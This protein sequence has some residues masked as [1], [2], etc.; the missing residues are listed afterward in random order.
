[1]SKDWQTEDGLK[2]IAAYVKENIKNRAG[3]LNENR[4]EWF[5]GNAMCLNRPW[6]AQG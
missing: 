5:K 1:M 4:C 6:P 2:K 3:V